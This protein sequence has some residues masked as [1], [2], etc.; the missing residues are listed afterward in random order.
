MPY[1]T[2][3]AVK[4]A[5]RW[6]TRLGKLAGNLAFEHVAKMHIKKNDEPPSDVGSQTNTDEPTGFL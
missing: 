2:M 5:R 4:S 1:L 3:P 6:A